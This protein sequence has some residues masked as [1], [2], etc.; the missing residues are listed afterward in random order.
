MGLRDF[1]VWFILSGKFIE[2]P[3]GNAI[4]TIAQ[5]LIGL[6]LIAAILLQSSSEGAGSTFGGGG[7]V[8]Q[9]KRGWEKKLF[10]GTIILGAAFLLVNLLNLL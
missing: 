5:G 2:M 1:L 7:R 4:L 3:S 6:L 9:T 8:W 10:T